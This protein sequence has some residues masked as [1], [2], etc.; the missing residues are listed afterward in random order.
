MPDLTADHFDE[1]FGV[2]YEAE[3]FPWQS[4]LAKRVIERRTAAWPA[5]IALP[6]AAGKTACIDIAVFALACHANRASSER[7]APR[8]I[9]FVVDRRIIV[10]EAHRRATMLAMKLRSAKRGIVKEVADRLRIL[11]GGDEPLACFHLR[12]GVYRDDAWART[13]IQPTVISSTVDQIGSRLLFR[14]YGRS[15]RTWSIHAG[16]A[17]NDS[18]ILLDEAHCAR[19]FLET[20]QAVASYRQWADAPIWSP[21]HTVVLSATPPEDRT[22]VFRDDARDRAHP[23]LGARLKAEK[24]TALCVAARSANANALVDELVERARGLVSEDSLAIGII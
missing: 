23:V 16:L 22:D 15:S 5:A 4:R 14:G 12:G 2:L 24:P 13:P 6:T 9:F 18:L 11:A 1:F 10:D 20:L 8:R 17:C 7:T 21:F 19:P 3:P